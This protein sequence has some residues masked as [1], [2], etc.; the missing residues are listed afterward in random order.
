VFSSPPEVVSDHQHF[1]AGNFVFTRGADHLIVDPS[2][3]GGQ[4]TLGSNAIAVDA[5]LTGDYAMTQ[6][7]WSEAELVWARGTADAVYG[8]RSDFA[9]AFI[10]SDTPSKIAY[11]HRE[12]VMLPEGEIVTIDRVATADAAHVA[13]LSFH[14]NTGGT[15]ALSGSV[16]S[17]KVG[18][19]TVAIHAVSLSGGTPAITKSPVGDCPSSCSF[20]CGKCEAARFAVDDY[21]VKVPGPWA[22]AIHAIDGLASGEAP[23][24][25]G[26]INDDTYDPAPKQNAAVIGAAVFRA[27][28][29]SYVLASSAKNGVAGSTIT[30]AVPGTSGARH[31]VFDAPEDSTGSSLVTAAAKDG[32]CVVTITAGTGFTGHPLMFSIASVTEGCKATDSTAAPSATPPDAGPGDGGADGGPG[33]DASVDG[34]SA[35]GGG[36]DGG[37]DGD[38]VDGGGGGDGGGCGCMLPTTAANDR[39]VAVAAGLIIAFA[40]RRRRR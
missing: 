25:V 14:A 7:P 38:V 36:S 31:I 16:A 10:F 6:T 12:W 30:Y 37:V 11:A 34:G 9:K 21:K 35:D 24:A 22:V 27:S 1:A 8:A 5:D 17:G 4:A 23:A 3:Y 26:S 29:Q 15:L 19:S 28:K 33:V 2:V 40:V 20:P 13:Y 39:F 18:G 32:R